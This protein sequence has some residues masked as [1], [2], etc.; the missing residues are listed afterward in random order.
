[1]GHKDTAPLI[2]IVDDD[3]GYATALARLLT[4]EGFTTA[5]FASAETYLNAVLV[6]VPHCLIVDISLPGMSGLELLAHVRA[7][8]AAPPVIV[9]TGELHASTRRQAETLGASAWFEKP[10]QS[11]VLIQA[12]ANVSPGN[13]A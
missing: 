4:A 5:V 10:I 8:G 2:A 11:S 13:P 6:P 1:L 12:I 7:T 3:A 9:V